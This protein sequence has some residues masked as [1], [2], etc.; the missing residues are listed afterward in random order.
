MNGENIKV[1][2]DTIAPVYEC[3]HMYEYGVTGR[4]IGLGIKF[5]LGHVPIAIHS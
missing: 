3:L 2:A 4:L 1:P 5:A